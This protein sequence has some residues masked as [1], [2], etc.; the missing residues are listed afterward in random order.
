[1]RDLIDLRADAFQ[2]VR[3]TINDRVEQVDQH[4]FSG[5]GRRANPRKLIADDHERTRVVVTHRD[6]PMVG[7]DKGHRCRLRR[8]GI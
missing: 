4:P 8:H 6:E 7:Q 1:V 5:H 3:R 2:N